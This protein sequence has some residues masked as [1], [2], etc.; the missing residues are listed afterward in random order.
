MRLMSALLNIIIPVVAV[1]VSYSLAQVEP[2]VR[3]FLGVPPITHGPFIPDFREIF[4]ISYVPFLMLHLLGRAISRFF[5]LAQKREVLFAIMESVL[6]SVSIS[7]FF[8]CTGKDQISISVFSG[9][10]LVG[11]SFLISQFAFLI[12]KTGLGKLNPR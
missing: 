2:L 11:V 3:N 12:V 4:V 5:E 1:V 9:P 10:F 6:F 7:A 8:Y